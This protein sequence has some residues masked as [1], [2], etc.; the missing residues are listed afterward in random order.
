MT[1]IIAV[2]SGKGG[3]GKTTMTAN[4]GSALVDMGY[5]V[6]VVDTNLTT[7]NLGFHLGYSIS[8]VT[9]HDVLKGK[10]SIHDSIYTNEKGLRIIPAGLSI[11]DMRGIDAR[12]MSSILLDLL[13]QADIVLLD[14]AAGL[15]K[16]SLASLESADELL[17]IT[18]PDITHITD[19]IKTIKLAE[20]VGTKTLG[21]IVNRVSGQRYEMTRSE[22]NSML[23]GYQ[24]IGEVPENNDIKRALSIKNPVVNS[25]PGSSS[26]VAIRRIAK[27]LIDEPQEEPTTPI[28]KRLINIFRSVPRL[29]D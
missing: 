14:S 23:D 10:E 21:V 18:Q 13:G 17:I 15:G 22:I 26:S 8:P 7:P 27:I 19:A 9:L 12:D 29:R 20:Q 1:R 28:H 25:F 2:S 4:I 24:I 11:T 6:I 16:E 3:A 5:S